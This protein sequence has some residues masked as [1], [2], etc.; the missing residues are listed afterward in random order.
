MHE[1]AQ[2]TESEEIVWQCDAEGLSMRK[3]TQ[4]IDFELLSR[5]AATTD[6]FGQFLSYLESR[7]FL[8]RG[9]KSYRS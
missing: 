6:S 9:C 7:S 2:I 8:L 3:E 4:Q 1:K 5:A